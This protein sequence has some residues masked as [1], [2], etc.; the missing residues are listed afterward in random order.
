MIENVCVLSRS[1]SRNETLKKRLASN[2]SIVKYN[3]TGLTLSGEALTQFCSGY[4]AIIPGLEKID[5]NVLIE[6]QKEGLKIISKYGVGTDKIDL[7][8]AADLGIPVVVSKGVNNVSV[9]ELSIFFAIGLRRRLFHAISEVQNLKWEQHLG[10]ELLGSTVGIF[11]AGVIGSFVAKKYREMGCEVLVHDIEDRSVLEREFG[12]IQVGKKE[13][14]EK[15]QIIS[16]HL[17]G[18]AD[19]VNI[20]SFEDMLQMKGAT[21]INCGRGDAIELVGLAKAIEASHIHS[22]A[23]D[24]LPIEPPKPDYIFSRLLELGAIITPHLGGSSNQAIL[25]MGHAA[26]DNLLKFPKGIR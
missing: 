15:S 3:D 22:V 14:L 17:P 1:F 8:A 16:M 19:T 26:I 21:L 6:L 12:C 2:F 18:N 4:D 5:N 20:V 7:V 9:A 25:N 13:L 10:D 11:G 24:V 23:L